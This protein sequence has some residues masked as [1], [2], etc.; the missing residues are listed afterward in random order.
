MTASSRAQQARID[1]LP[2]RAAQLNHIGDGLSVCFQTTRVCCQT[3]RRRNRLLLICHHI[4]DCDK[5]GEYGQLIP[6]TNSPPIPLDQ[7]IPSSPTAITNSSPRPSIPYQLIPSHRPNVTNSS[8]TH[9]YIVGYLIRFKV[10]HTGSQRLLILWK[11]NEKQ[12]Y[13]I[14][15]TSN[16]KGSISVKV[17]LFKQLIRRHHI[18]GKHLLQYLLQYLMFDIISNPCIVFK[19]YKIFVEVIRDNP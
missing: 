7:L 16:R 13:L 17:Y 6:P 8:P 15:F 3:R 12:I 5:G 9:D 14:I 10:R 1:P 19:K 2:S 11:C 18:Y 4:T